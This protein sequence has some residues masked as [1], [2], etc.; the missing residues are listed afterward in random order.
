LGESPRKTF[1]YYYRKNSLEAVRMGNWKLV[2]EHKGRSYMNQLPGNDGFAG[3][4]PE[5]I[6]TPMALYDLRR[7]PSEQYDVQKL[8]PEIVAEL[9]IIAEEARED[10]GDDLT[11]RKGKNVRVSG[12]V[13]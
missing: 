4:S 8:Y 12:L 11:S 1:L 7:D 2:F 5:D 3:A 9:Q 6:L 10:L 13:E